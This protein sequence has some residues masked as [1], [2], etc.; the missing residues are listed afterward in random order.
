MEEKIDNQVLATLTTELS[1][2]N[3]KQIEQTLKLLLAGNT[4]PFIARYRKEVTGS[5][6]EVQIKL[7]EER[8]QYL[9]NLNKRKEEIIASISEQGK[10]TETLKNEIMSASV[11]Q[12]VEDLYRP[13]KQKRR[14]KATIAKEN[15][16]QP[17]A[18]AIFSQASDL[19]VE[20]L[21]GQFLNE[22]I[23]DITQAL[24]GA[25][26]I[27]AEQIAD[28]AQ[29]RQWIRQY[30]FNH[31]VYTSTVKDETLDEKQVYQ[32][33]YDFEQPLKTMVSHRT[34]ATNRGEKEG[35]LKVAIVVAAEAI[36]QYF[37]KQLITNPQSPAYPLIVEAY[38][39]AYKR[40]IQPAIEREL[41]SELTQRADEQAIDVFGD[42]LRNLLL[43]APLKGKVVMGFDPAY[44]TGCKLAILDETGKVL[45]IDVIY[46]HN[47]APKEKQA[48][49]GHK[50]LDLLEKYQVEMI[51]IGNGT[52]S[53][54]SEQFVADQLKKLKRK[55]YYVIVNEAGASVYSASEAARMEFPDL[56]VEQRSAVSIGRRLQDPLAELVKIDPKSV[57]VGQYQHDVAQK[58]L[59]EK[60]DFVV[61]TVV[62]QVGVNV[63]TA[64]SELLTHVAGLNKT[65]AQNIVTYR[66]ENGLFTNRKQLAKVP[67]LGPKAFEQAVG[68][69]R[70]P[71]GQLILDNTEIHPE[72]Y[73]LTEQLLAKCQI[74]LAEIGRPATQKKLA[75]L[76]VAQ[77]AEQL[78]TGVE[79]LNDII[80]SLQ[81][82]GRD[83]RDEMEAPLLRSD[84][85]SIDDLQVGMELEGTVR[86]VIDFGAFVDI[87]VKQD[88]LVHISKMSRSFVKHP[89]DVV[90]V[91]EI[92]HVWITQ[93]D[94]EKGRIGLSMIP[95]ELDD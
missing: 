50:L 16:L 69:L 94:R 47:P 11:L 76:N 42:N 61:E 29:F 8:Y 66:Q 84:V 31:G 35:I 15:G 44:R 93:V 21:A 34:L 79:T 39:D 28:S 37:E 77:L 4:V 20:Q 19:V 36:E 30:T 23:V 67:R 46:P 41:R 95:V 65:I 52:A 5:L 64:S 48:Q 27:L 24:A 14:T 3:K 56:Q 71:D 54:E 72:S 1:G 43:Q 13:F 75:E 53:R 74:S 7:I 81:K 57:G 80:Q 87:G 45:A 49:A 60:L 83:L 25:H 17:L 91:G 82:P 58:Q 33:Y 85:L 89:S 73:D 26:E 55:V 88:G 51:A 38:K 6:D 63:N 2:I 86:N 62:N 78:A 22:Q 68:F 40:F 32:M 90:A 12:R 18:D 59:N 10:L 92:V 70:I 9:M